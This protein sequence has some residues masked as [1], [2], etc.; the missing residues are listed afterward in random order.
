MCALLRVN[1]DLPH[2]IPAQLD[3][4]PGACIMHKGTIEYIDIGAC[5]INVNRCST[6]TKLPAL[7]NLTHGR[8]INC[9]TPHDTYYTAPF[10]IRLLLNKET[11]PGGLIGVAPWGCNN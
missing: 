6:K 1:T 10:V 4:P 8:S 3:K 5:D 9:H 7:L 2:F 11:H